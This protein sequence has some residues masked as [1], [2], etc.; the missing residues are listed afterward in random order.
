MDCILDILTPLEDIHLSYRFAPTGNF[1]WGR[2]INY[3]LKGGGEKQLKNLPAVIIVRPSYRS[4]PLLPVSGTTFT[5]LLPF[6]NSWR[7]V[8][9]SWAGALAFPIM[10][11]SNI[12]FLPLSGLII[13]RI[14]I[15]EC[16]VISA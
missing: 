11:N 2:I 12:W 13:Q 9:G 8:F 1:L 5:H 7:P 6:P 4:F 15:I 3:Q 16:A 10:K 14:E